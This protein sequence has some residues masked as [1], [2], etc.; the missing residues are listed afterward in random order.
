MSLLLSRGV[1][2]EERSSTYLLE[3]HG[4]L[5]A[6]WAWEETAEEEKVAPATHAK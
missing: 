4:G 2:G 6:L 3:T 5:P 1:K